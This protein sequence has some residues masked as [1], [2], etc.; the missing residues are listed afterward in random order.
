M[1]SQSFPSHMLIDSRLVVDKVFIDSEGS[2]SWT[3]GHQLH[4]YLLDV[5]LDGVAL[6]PV[7]FVLI[8]GSVVVRVF[9]TAMTLGGADTLGTGRPRT[10]DV[11]L[12]GLDLIGLT[13]LTTAVVTSGDQSL[14][15]PVGPGSSGEASI[16]SKATAVATGQE[17]LRRHVR[18][19]LSI[20]VDTD[21]IRHGCHGSKSPA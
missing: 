16:A 9:T 17:V 1:T 18:V 5:I 20:G 7:G 19:F 21:P 12:A 2:L 15:C 6:L 3:I 14:T 10:I 13:S 11:V 4:L 8:I